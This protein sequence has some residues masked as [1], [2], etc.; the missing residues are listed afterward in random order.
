M[1][2]QLQRR[3]AQAAQ[4]SGDES[5]RDASLRGETTSARLQLPLI[6]IF[7]SSEKKKKRHFASFDFGEKS[8][9]RVPAG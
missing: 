2:F 8:S 1:C 9:D 4:T 5:E 6:K 3:R 7:D